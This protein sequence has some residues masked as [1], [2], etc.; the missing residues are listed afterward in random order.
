MD[1]LKRVMIQVGAKADDGTITML[2]DRYTSMA[3]A[4]TRYDTLPARVEPFVETAVVAAYRR[5]GNEGLKSESS[6]GVSESYVDIED[7]LRK[8]LRG[9]VNPLSVAAPRPTPIQ[10][11]APDRDAESDGDIDA[12]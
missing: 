6:I 10:P 1:M 2:I 11:P 4:L 7:A 5:I 3:C 9:L 12:G 8:S